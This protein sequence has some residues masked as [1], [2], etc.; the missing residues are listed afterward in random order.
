MPILGY[1]AIIVVGF[2]SILLELNW[3]TSAPPQPKPAINAAAGSALTTAQA[4]PVVK[5]AEPVAVAEASAAPPKAPP[6]GP[7]KVLSPV[8]PTTAGAPKFNPAV[9]VPAPI[10]AASETQAIASTQQPAPSATQPVSNNPNVMPV[11]DTA[12]PR[13][14]AAETTGVATREPAGESESKPAVTRPEAVVASANAEKAT[15]ED[16]RAKSG[17]AKSAAVKTAAAGSCN[18]SACAGAYS[19][20]RASDCTYQSFG[21]QRKVCQMTPDASRRTAET[22]RPPRV[23]HAR[24]DGGPEDLRGIEAAVRQLDSGSRSRIY[25]AGSRRVPADIE[26]QADDDDGSVVIIRQGSARGGLW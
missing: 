12:T 13:R 10:G 3:L 7:N 23:D 15:A 9:N 8:Y 5:A 21:G 14:A 11:M 26:A 2:S 20:F 18:I 24:A 17:A 4:V 19:S 6:D 16:A 22:R 1:I 25:R